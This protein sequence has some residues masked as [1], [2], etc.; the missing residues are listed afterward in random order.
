M[1]AAYAG[2]DVGGTSVK[3]L[4][5]DEEGKILDEDS[6]ESH[7]DG[8]VEL[9]QEVAAQLVERTPQISGIGVIT[10]GIVDAEA[11]VVHYASNLKLSNV[12]LA[13]EV[14]Q[15]SAR[16]AR[17]DHDGRGAGFAESFYGAAK[18]WASSV[19]VPIGTGISAALCFPDRVWEGETFQAGEIGHIP[20]YPG[21]EACSCGQ[22]GCLEVYASARNIGLRY[23]TRTGK[24]PSAREVERCLGKDPLADEVWAEA[25]EALALVLA[26]L[27]FTLDPGAFVIAG[28][29]SGAGDKLLTP[30]RKALS[31]HLAWRE[32]PPVVAS[33]LGAMVG[34]WGAAVLGCKAAGSLSYEAWHV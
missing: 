16:P 5:V 30:V 4:V 34:R 23:A 7:P 17:L 2:I 33:R 6:R 24:P 13:A 21:G 10:P 14:A 9:V 27:T 28:G 22:R 32:P 15:A 11:G 20:V 3:S 26:Q 18:E 1:N 29:L 25:T 8:I 19:V 12:A 31:R